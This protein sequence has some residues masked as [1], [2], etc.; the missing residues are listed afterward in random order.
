MLRRT[1]AVIRAVADGAAPAHSHPGLTLL[2]QLSSLHN[3][4]CL[5]YI[6]SCTRLIAAPK[7][8]GTL[9]YYYDIAVADKAKIWARSDNKRRREL[10]AEMAQCTFHPRCLL[11][12]KAMHRN[13]VGDFNRRGLEWLAHR[14]KKLEKK[15]ATDAADRAELEQEEFKKWELSVASRRAYEERQRRLEAVARGGDFTDSASSVSSSN[16]SDSDASS[17]STDATR[18][19][20]SHRTPRRRDP[21]VTPPRATYRRQAYTDPRT[22]HPQTQAHP[23]HE[24]M[25]KTPLI[26]RL[27]HHTPRPSRTLEAFRA[28]EQAAQ[29]RIDHGRMREADREK[30]VGRLHVPRRLPNHLRPACAAIAGRTHQCA[31]VAP[32]GTAECT[33]SPRS[34]RRPG[35]SC[36]RATRG[37][38]GRSGGTPRRQ[39]LPRP[40]G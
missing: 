27:T 20:R 12:S 18:E 22:W 28:E 2:D 7:P 35:P 39:T 17:A 6:A 26:E 33:F 40:S 10:A 21:N 36:L 31:G 38:C 1:A 9:T 11:A 37:S 8:R 29:D 3:Q 34:A 16:D 23:Y 14:E 15:R 30:V 5:R 13:K 4:P 19:H 24:E 32:S 25:A